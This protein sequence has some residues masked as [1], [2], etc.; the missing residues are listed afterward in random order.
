MSFAPRPSVQPWARVNKSRKSQIFLASVL[1]LTL[2]ALIVFFTGLDQNWA[3]VGVFLPLQLVAAS[4]VGFL[5]FGRR[6][7]GD[8]FLIVLVVFLSTFVLVL[9]VSVIVSF[10]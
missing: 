8:S 9:L 5:A 4:L 6:G 10:V 3:L 7:V 2:S 1:P